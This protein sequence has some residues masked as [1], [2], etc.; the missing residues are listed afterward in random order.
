MSVTY[1]IV[2]GSLCPSSFFDDKYIIHCLV[3]QVVLGSNPMG[4]M[5]AIIADGLGAAR[6]S[7]GAVSLRG[8]LTEP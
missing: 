2:S 4:V 1:Y 8:L 7:K 5:T 3:S 6:A